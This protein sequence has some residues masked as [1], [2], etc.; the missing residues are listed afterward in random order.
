MILVRRVS[1]DVRL[2]LVI[3]DSPEPVAAS[4]RFALDRSLADQAEMLAVRALGRSRAEC[5]VSRSHTRGLAAA[6]AAPAP[7]RL[8][9]DVVRLDR[10]TRR[11]GDAVTGPREREA[12]ARYGPIAAALA[13]TLKEAAAKATGDPGRCFPNGLQIT[14]AGAGLAVRWGSRTFRAR[15]MPVA[16]FLCAWVRA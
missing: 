12:L 13:W 8:G 4:A 10:V 15:W 14:A 1:P 2:G 7:M 5:A 3:P 9:V 16:G 11:H 6:L